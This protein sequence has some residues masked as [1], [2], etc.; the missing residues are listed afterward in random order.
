LEGIKSWQEE[1]VEL[2]LR[3]LVLG[4]FKKLILDEPRDVFLSLLRILGGNLEQRG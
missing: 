2:E 3:L 1:K 4:V